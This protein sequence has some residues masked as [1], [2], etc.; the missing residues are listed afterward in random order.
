MGFFFTALAVIIGSLIVG[1]MIIFGIIRFLLGS[2]GSTGPGW[3]SQITNNPRFT[4]NLPMLIGLAIF[5]LFWT[6]IADYLAGWFASSDMGAAFDL[7]EDTVRGLLWVPFLFV[8]I[9]VLTNLMGL[10]KVSTGAQGAITALFLLGIGGLM[11][12]AFF[13]G[14]GAHR[15]G[16]GL[17]DRS[18]GPAN[19][20]EIMTHEVVTVG[21][22]PGEWAT[23]QPEN[24]LPPTVRFNNLSTGEA[25]AFSDLG[26][27][28]YHFI[29][30]RQVGSGLF[31]VTALQTGF[32]NSNRDSIELVF[33][34]SR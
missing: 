14:S 15:V 28:P 19:R 8:A 27:T 32:T 17:I 7:G 9:G 30:V 3:F 12:S 2:S 34:I 1:A 16:C 26:V 24:G 4:R 25:T 5:F 33:T 10:K 6:P 18:T 13:E 23:L 22:C 20:I 31:Q 21:V 29:E 11:Y